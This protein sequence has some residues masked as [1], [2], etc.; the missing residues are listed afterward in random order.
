MI[1]SVCCAKFGVAETTKR[2]VRVDGTS[3][4]LVLICEECGELTVLGGPLSVWLSGS[5]SFACECS[6]RLTL[7]DSLDQRKVGAEL[8]EA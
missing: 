7:A 1:D 4:R 5:T 8:R 3:E 6:S 2:G